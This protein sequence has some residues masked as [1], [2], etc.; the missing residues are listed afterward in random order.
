MM[1]SDE[2]QKAFFEAKAL[3]GDWGFGSIRAADP[4][5]DAA[6]ND[7][8]K[9]FHLRLSALR[10]MARSDDLTPRMLL[11]AVDQTMEHFQNWGGMVDPNAFA[12]IEG[13][14]S[15]IRRQ[16]ELAAANDMSNADIGIE[17]A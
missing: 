2:Q 3:L 8:A 4:A 17:V 6:L 9:Q 5:N 13:T 15:T 16:L 11:N 14:F 12:E 1:L 7:A 10:E